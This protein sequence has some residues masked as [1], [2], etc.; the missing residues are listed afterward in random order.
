M[1]KPVLMIFSFFI[2]LKISVLIAG[3]TS[4]SAPAF[5]GVVKNQNP[6]PS[7]AQLLNPDMA[8]QDEFGSEYV[9]WKFIKELKKNESFVGMYDDVGLS[10]IGYKPVLSLNGIGAI[11]NQK[12]SE[13]QINRLIRDN[14]NYF[15]VPTSAIDLPTINPGYSRSIFWNLDDSRYTPCLSWPSEVSTSAPA[16]LW[17]IQDTMKI[18]SNQSTKEVYVTHKKR[19][20]RLHNLSN[21]QQSNSIAPYTLSMISHEKSKYIF[22]FKANSFNYFKEKNPI[23]FNT[24]ILTNYSYTYVELSGIHL[25]NR[26]VNSAT[27]PARC[28]K[29]KCHIILENKEPNSII[30]L[31]LNGFNNIE[32]MTLTKLR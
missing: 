21:L 10:F 1:F 13:N 5:A 23:N 28:S 25:K 22:E 15:F 3:S 20:E 14:K 8:M 24:M 9:A 16:V 7:M 31:T 12:V 2:L 30:Q 29:T 18:C 4:E 27:L 19:S 32:S 17:T 11:E 6:F 26:I